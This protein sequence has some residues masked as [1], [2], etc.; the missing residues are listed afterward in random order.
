MDIFDFLWAVF[1]GVISS[2][3]IVGYTYSESERK[4]FNLYINN[5]F[6]EIEHNRRKLP[7]YSTYLAEVKTEWTQN[8]NLNWIDNNEI[9]V[10]YGNYLY[11]YF[12]FDAYNLFT[13]TGL[14]LYLESGLDYN[15]KLFYYN[16]KHFCATTQKIEDQMRIDQVQYANFDILKR[17]EKIEEEYKIICKIFEDNLMFSGENRQKFQ[18]SWINWHIK[19]IRI[20]NGCEMEGRLTRL[21]KF[22]LPYGTES[23]Q[24]W[25]LSLGSIGMIWLGIFLLLNGAPFSL[26][27]ATFSL[28]NSAGFFMMSFGF[29]LLLFAFNRHSSIGSRKKMDE[30]IGILR[31]MR[32]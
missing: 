23:V 19:R 2:I 4:K 18:I 10:G 21:K 14:N 32:R 29:A 27:P 30:I 28:M 25:V 26:V 17:F 20:I 16:C 1:A 7:N 3:I 31:E 8:N 24:Y 15:L 9:S 13:G 11:N 22:L 12:K 6:E 5:L